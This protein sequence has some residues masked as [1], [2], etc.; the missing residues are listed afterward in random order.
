MKHTL[1]V[2]LYSITFGVEFNT[3]SEGHV[4]QLR[5]LVDH[6]LLQEYAARSPNIN[7]EE[8][9]EQRVPQHTNPYPLLCRIL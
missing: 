7:V 6:K 4:K 1:A 2:P 9:I 8:R 3:S 5:L